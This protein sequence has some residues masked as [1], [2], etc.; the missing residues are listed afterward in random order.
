LHVRRGDFV[1]LN[2][3]ARVHGLCSVD[4]Y[5]RAINLVRSRCPGCH[6]LVFSDDPQWARAELPLDPSA[7][8]VTGNAERPEQDLILMSACGHHI[9]ANSSFSWWGAWLA[10]SQA[11]VVIAPKQWFLNAPRDTSDLIP[12]GWIRL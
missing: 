11:K 2:S 8:F 6:F 9:I 3:A 5:A 7:V 10:A 1:S 4:Y 12:D